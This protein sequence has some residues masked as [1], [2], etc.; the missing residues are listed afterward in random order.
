MLS[1]SAY[2]WR[3]RGDIASKLAPPFVRER[4]CCA[5]SLA[6]FTAPNSALV[7]LRKTAGVRATHS[8]NEKAVQPHDFFIWRRRGDSN[9]RYRSPRT[10]DLANRPLQPLG[11]SSVYVEFR[12]TQLPLKTHHLF[13]ARRLKRTVSVQ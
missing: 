3:R 10:N 5:L 1:H 13:P 12:Y 9:S 11:Y 6:S 8:P 2:A 7:L 4:K